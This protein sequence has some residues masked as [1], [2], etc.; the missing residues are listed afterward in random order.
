[1]KAV[2]HRH[3]ATD[4]MSQKLKYETIDLASHAV[5]LAVVGDIVTVKSGGDTM[6]AA[7]LGEKDYITIEQ[8]P[9]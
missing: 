9:A 7:K 6:A 5:T 2:L 4:P 8:E 3:I 1:M